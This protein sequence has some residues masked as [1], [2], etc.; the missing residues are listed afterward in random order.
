MELKDDACARLLWWSLTPALGDIHE[1]NAEKEDIAMNSIEFLEFLT[2]RAKKFRLDRGH[3]KRN[4]HMHRITEP[5]SQEVIDAVLVGFIN[6]IGISRGI[7]YALYTTD[8]EKD[9][10]P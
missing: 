7:D 9:I 10:A 4:E 2:R 5:P 1:T 8:L 6:D 3:Y